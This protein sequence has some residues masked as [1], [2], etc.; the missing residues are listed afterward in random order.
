MATFSEDILQ[1]YYDTRNYE[2]AIDYLSS[3][4]GK[5]YSS[6]VQINNIIS[7]LKVK[8]AKQKSYVNSLGE[9]NYEAFEF[10]QGV[11]G[12]GTIP[13]NR[14]ITYQDGT[15][16]K[17][18][19]KWGQEYTKNL[20]SLKSNNGNDITSIAI[21]IN[22]EDNFNKFKSELGIENINNNDL[23][24]TYKALGNDQHRI[25]VSK[26]NN[27]LY[28]TVNAANRITERNFWDIFNN[29]GSYVTAGTT[30][31]GVGGGL[32][33]GP[34]GVVA[35]GLLGAGTGLL[36]GAIDESIKAVTNRNRLNVKGLDANGN[37]YSEDE[38][39]SSNLKK[40]ISTVNDAKEIYDKAL[41]NY[42]KET[43]FTSE[44][45]ET[46]FLGAGHAEAYDAKRRGLIN[47]ATYD[48]IV[49]NWHDA[50]D[51]LIRRADFAQYPVYA[52]SLDSGQGKVLTKINNTDAPDLQ[53]E[54][55]S[56]MKDGRVDY[57]LSIINGELGT[58]IVITPEPE[59]SGSNWSKKKGEVYK[60]IFIPGL[61]D[62]TA[63]DAFNRDTK[64]MSAKQNA[65]M[66]RWNYELNLTNG[67]T[68]G[69]NQIYGSYKKT[70][71]NGEEQFTSIPEAELL[72]NLN[73]SNVIDQSVNEVLANLDNNGKLFDRAKDGS[74]IE[75]SIDQ[76]L[77]IL[78]TAGANELY[79][80]GSITDS[81][82]VLL[83]NEL[84]K[85]MRNKFD[86]Q[87]KTIKQN[88]NS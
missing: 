87:Y 28:K 67:A 60:E 18:R 45:V 41:S 17:Y 21:D 66:K 8:A 12:N 61:H 14:N 70:Y 38:F 88:R 22:G 53:A 43:N 71:K 34:L 11:N 65:D 40:A 56:A 16:V 10:M 54:V 64:T 77:L 31:G 47:Q 20:N 80:Q 25:I 68:V 29:I 19:N 48:A 24:I 4:Q 84:Y 76:M 85:K 55:L 36:T 39:N 83:Q 58:K 46:Q 73:E 26:A 23:G 52:W 78:S 1:S 82:R 5:D 3:F 33:A 7:N 74:L 15:V 6:Q 32:I 9:D 50:Y 49:K 35:G 57:G 2:G 27:N 44:S 79:P 72:Y 81:Q 13:Y 59:K 30:T 37:I 69:Y 51:T 75:I 42:Q 86:A 63:E 62:G